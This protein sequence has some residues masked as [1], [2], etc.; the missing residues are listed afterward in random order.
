MMDTLLGDDWSLWEPIQ[1]LQWTEELVDVGAQP[2]TGL[3]SAE[4]KSIV[5]DH[6]WDSIEHLVGD[7]DIIDADFFDWLENK[8]DLKDFDITATELPEIIPPPEDETTI[9]TA[10]SPAPTETD[11]VAIFMSLEESD[12]QS[13]DSCESSP[14]AS[15]SSVNQ[16]VPTR[17]PKGRGRKKNDESSR[18]GLNAQSKKCRKRDQNRDAA[19]RYRQKKR[20]EA[21]TIHQERVALEERNVE[22]RR[23][24]EGLA[25]EVKYLKGLLKELFD[26][27]RK[28]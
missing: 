9:C 6:Q 7:A 17:V 25:S 14:P 22:L 4:G 5:P 8:A 23:K 2:K 19:L 13:D 12:S 28:L 21:N 16:E 3:P 20:E 26:A 24:A 18:L 11:A 1:G 27:R 10:A 15:P